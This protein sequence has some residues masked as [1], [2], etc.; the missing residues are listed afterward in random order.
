MVDGCIRAP[1]QLALPYF[2]VVHIAGSGSIEG[3]S[4]VVW[5]CIGMTSRALW[6]CRHMGFIPRFFSFSWFEAFTS[7]YFL[8]CEFTDNFQ[9][10]TRNKTYWWR[11]PKCLAKVCSWAFA[12]LNLWSHANA[13]LLSSLQLYRSLLA[14][15]LKMCRN[16]EQRT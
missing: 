2:K 13:K 3:S 7:E 5:L 4:L 10:V 16:W 14:G 6:K 11:R 9:Y 1:K 15:M 8:R 12:K